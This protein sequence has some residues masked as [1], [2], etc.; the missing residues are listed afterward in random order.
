MSVRVLRLEVEE[1]PDDQVRDLV[2]DR[3]AEED[4][5]VA[6]QP[7]VQVERPL[8]A[9]VRLEHGRN[10]RHGLLLVAYRATMWLPI[11]RN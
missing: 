9:V 1:L 7:G 6:Q 11:I 4:D 3:A 10:Q 8:R 5:A 2:V